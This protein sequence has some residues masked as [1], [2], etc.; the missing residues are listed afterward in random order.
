MVL[1]KLDIHIP[2]TKTQ[3]QTNKNKQTNSQTENLHHSQKLTQN[4]IDLK[5]KYNTAKILEDNRRG[6]LHDLGYDDIFLET[7]PKA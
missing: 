6:N 4:V 2:K 3:K 1:G 7:T 5:A